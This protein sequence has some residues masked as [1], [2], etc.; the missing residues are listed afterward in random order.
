MPVMIRSRAAA[1]GAILAL[2]FTALGFMALA[3]PAR[4]AD[5]PIRVN[6]FPNA[7]A[8]P[9]YV[10]IARGFFTNMGSA[11]KSSTPRVRRASV[12]ASPPADSRSPRRRSTMRSP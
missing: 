5:A 3:L 4:A 9:V 7:K 12:T 1:L 10:G 11:S 6:T 8:L 2:G